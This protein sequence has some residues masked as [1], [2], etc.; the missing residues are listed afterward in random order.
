MKDYV[1]SNQPA[2]RDLMYFIIAGG[3]EESEYDDMT[4]TWNQLIVQE[5]P[6]FN[7]HRLVDLFGEEFLNETIQG[8]SFR[9]PQGYSGDYQIIDFIYEQT[10]IASDRYSK[11]DKYFHYASAAKAV[12]NRKEYFIQLVK[13]RLEKSD[14]PLRVLNIASGPCR[15]V[16]ELFQEVSPSLLQMHCVD[17]VANAIQY[18]KDLLGDYSAEVQFTRANIFKFDTDK[19]YDLVWSAGLFDYFTDEDFVK[20]LSKIY[21]WSALNGEVVVGNFSTENPTRSYMEKGSD[22]FLFHRTPKELISLGTKVKSSG[23]QVELRKETLGINLFLHLKKN[24]H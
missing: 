24:G 19:K 12:R 10:I 22:W 3:P 4:N 18:A 13:S 15:D 11:W 2:F 16:F 8:H 5:R 20:I 7:G 14:T 1:F 9:K 17:L 21:S 23:D 6:T